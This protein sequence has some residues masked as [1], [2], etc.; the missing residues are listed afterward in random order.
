MQV[1]LLGESASLS[2]QELSFDDEI[3]DTAI[4][5]TNSIVTGSNNSS[6]MRK[7]SISSIGTGGTK[8]FFS[9][10]TSDINGLATQTTSMFSDLFGEDL[11]TFYTT[12]VSL[13]S[14]LIQFVALNC[15]YF[16]VLL[17]S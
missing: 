10:I 4:S 5:S 1:G 16:L 9:D 2:Q 3:N 13:Y 17:S 6:E 11:Q 7:S 12:N 15:V 14:I 8:N